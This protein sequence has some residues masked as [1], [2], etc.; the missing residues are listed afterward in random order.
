[1]K[2]EPKHIGKL[3]K[4]INFEE[5]DELIMDYAGQ[6]WAIPVSILDWFDHIDQ[7]YSS[8]KE[9]VLYFIPPETLGMIVEIA[10]P[11]PKVT[12]NYA[13]VLLPKTFYEDP[14]NKY[15]R[16]PQTTKYPAGAYW[17]SGDFLEE[18]ETE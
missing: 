1:M 14:D 3:V 6:P 16:F 4:V 7:E 17:I 5:R 15:L 2:L 8:Y 11:V 10:N 18:I 12:I 9:E 13:K